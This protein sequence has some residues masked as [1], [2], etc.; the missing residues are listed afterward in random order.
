M[1]ILREKKANFDV[2]KLLQ[3][4]SSFV[5]VVPVV[6]GL[7]QYRQSVEETQDKNFREIVAHLSSDKKTERLAS[8]T[9]LGTFI[10]EE[11]P[12][13][14]E[15]IDTLVNM[16][17]I[18]SDTDILQAINSSFKGLTLKNIYHWLTNC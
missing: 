11:N 15:A 10:Y 5:V 13:N 9:S 7:F 18:E 4:L 16:I 2:I 3:S 12:R 8:A 6:L 17:L 14:D 1:P